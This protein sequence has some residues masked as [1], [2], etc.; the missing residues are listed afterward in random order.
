M[1]ENKNFEY[2]GGR[3]NGFV[4]L[5]VVLLSLAASVA[6]IVFGAIVLDGGYGVAVGALLLGAGIVLLVTTVILACG[7]M[8]IE[9]NQARV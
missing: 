2:S 3:C 6:T 5:L 9:P 8:L 4:M 1:K 7:F